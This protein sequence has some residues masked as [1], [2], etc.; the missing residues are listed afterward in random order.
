MPNEEN[1]IVLTDD[2][3]VRDVNRAD[4]NE[5]LSMLVEEPPG[6]PPHF[7][8]GSAENADCGD[9]QGDYRQSGAS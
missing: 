5:V 8:D 3:G 7:I 2:Y 1:Y 6:H 4:D 9:L